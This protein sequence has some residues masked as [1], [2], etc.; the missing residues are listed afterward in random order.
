MNNLI[1]LQNFFADYSVSC[2]VISI[3]ISLIVCLIDKFS[4][5]GIITKLNYAL[6]FI[7]GI[8]FNFVYNLIIGQINSNGA[9]VV[10]AGFMSG[11]LSFAMKVIVSSLLK[12]ES[13]PESKTAI[14]ITGLI[15]GYVS[16]NDV[17]SSVKFIEE[18]FVEGQGIEETQIVAEIALHLSQTSM[19]DLSEGDITALATLIY[20]SVKQTKE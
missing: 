15:Q 5:K 2:I 7:L 12:G 13:L 8:S 19:Q 20:A 4:I 18:L 11:S 3:I 6:P 17:E 9:Q 1:F 16:K 10:S 14:I